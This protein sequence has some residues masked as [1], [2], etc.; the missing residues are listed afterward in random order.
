VRPD[1]R[2]ADR[3]AIHVH[4]RITVS[5][6]SSWSWSLEEVLSEEARDAGMALLGDVLAAGYAGPFDL[7]LVGPRI[8]AEGYASAITR[9]ITALNDLLADLGA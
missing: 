4:P 7:E 9:S 1:G 2:C 5:Q 8:D 6:V 3:L